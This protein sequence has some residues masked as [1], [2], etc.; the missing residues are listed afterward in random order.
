MN[1]LSAM[2]LCVGLAAG[3]GVGMSLPRPQIKTLALTETS[4][5]VSPSGPMRAAA[6]EAQ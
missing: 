3:I 6:G 5:C 1:L 2:T 4:D